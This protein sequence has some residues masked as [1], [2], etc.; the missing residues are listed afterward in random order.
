MKAIICSE[1]GLPEKL[2]LMDVDSPPMGAGQ[3]RVRVRACS[4]NFPDTLIIQGLYQVRAQPPFS[5][6]SEVAGEVIE[7]AKDVEGLSPGDRVIALCVYGG[8]AEEVVVSR[9]A[10]LPM[11]EKMSFRQGA[12]FLL[13]YGTSY[14]ALK[15]R[16]QLKPGETVLVLGAS[17]GVGLTAVE[18]AKTMGTKVI[19]CASSQ[20][21]LE[22]TAKYGADEFI[23]YTESGFRDRIKELTGGKGVNVIYD[24]VGGDLFEQAFRAMAWGGRA[25]VIG[26]VAGI[27]AL[28]LNL[29][30]LKGSSVVGVFYGGFAANEPGENIRNNQ[31]LLQMF[32]EG[33]LR[34]C[35]SEGYTLPDVP[36]VLRKLMDRE[37]MGKL[38]VDI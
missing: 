10:V 7:V 30:L 15:Q 16:A 35:L 14:H 9:S 2:Q 3:V 22:L 6:G 13:A 17:G 36:V 37:A 23:N 34:P 31:E 28:P 1:Y 25:L 33:R 12:S 5:P 11:P 20:A 27:P 8:F 19:A 21:K 38:V 24:P 32:S 4:A 18:L 29:P 26:F